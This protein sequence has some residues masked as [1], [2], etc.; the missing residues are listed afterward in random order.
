MTYLRNHGYLLPNEDDECLSGYDRE[1]GFK[2]TLA[3]YHKFVEIF[4]VEELS[5]EQWDVAEEVIRLSTIYGDSKKFLMSTIKDRIGDKLTEKQKKRLLGMKFKD[6]GRLSKEFLEFEGIDNATGTLM[7]LIERMWVENKN[8]NGLLDQEKY[9][10]AAELEKRARKLNKSLSEIQPEDLEGRYLSAPVKRMVW[11]TIRV[12]QEIETI[13]G[14]EPTRVFVEMT[15]SHGK[16][17]ERKS[18]RKEAL[19]LLYK[20]CKE[21]EKDLLKVIERGEEADF[22]SH[23][24]FL[25]LLQKGRCMYTGERIELKD[26]YNKNL[27]DIDHIYPRHYTK[28]DSIHNNLVLVK[29]QENSAKKDVYPLSQDIRDKCRSMWDSLHDGGFINDE[30]YYRLTRREGFRDDE[31]V[32][33]INRQIVET[34]QGTKAVASILTEVFGGKSK[35]RVVYV[36]A[37]NVSDFRRLE[38]VQF[39]K[40]RDINDF[41][42]AQDAYLN[43]VVGNVYFTKFTRD[44]KNFI[45]ERK[46]DN[47][48]DKY[49]MDKLFD[50]KVQRNGYLAWDPDN[51]YDAVK[52]VLRKTTPIITRKCYE[53]HG[54]LSDRQP[55]SAKTMSDSKAILRLP[56]KSTNNK[57]LDMNKYGGYLNVSGTYFCLVEYK[58][59]KG[60]VRSI[61]PVPLYLASQMT[62]KEDLA[63][64]FADVYGYK[65]PKII[66]ERILKDS[67]LKIDGYYV[68]LASRYDDGR[69]TTNDAI[70]L[71]LDAKW[72][73]YIR[74][75]SK[76]VENKMSDEAIERDAKIAKASTNDKRVYISKEYNETLYDILTEKHVHGIYSKRPVGI[77]D[78]LVDGRDKFIG[79]ILSDQCYVLKQII[80]ICQTKISTG[81]LRKIGVKNNRVGESKRNKKFYKNDECKLIIQSVTGMY[82]REVDLLADEVKL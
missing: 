31:L 63:S 11:Q 71:K 16:K 36:K 24:L 43:I 37:N 4:G 77:G 1:Y 38:R 12:V 15:R 70:P 28:D 76:V 35:D 22:R 81:D 82:S 59:G 47:P 65:E 54:E 42:H 5:K 46:D 39:F 64:Y 73:N 14:F 23:K 30:K 52:K 29:K 67:L 33:F 74:E 40:C 60:M 69:I 20:N 34:G 75:I 66:L 61:E 8:L 41:H 44:A 18:S 56:L 17:G 53:V 58:S 6:W 10:Y 55:K 72:N 13:M 80:G 3:N 57:L 7:P 51:D 25:Y 62:N 9:T 19:K 79:L 32:G 21:D 49:N 50:K 48:D 27:Y 45:K 78:K 2:N 26:L 68:Y